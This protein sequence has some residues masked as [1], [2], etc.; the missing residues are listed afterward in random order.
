M[1]VF[2]LYLVTVLLIPLNAYPK[3][4]VEYRLVPAFPKLRFERPLDF[5]FAADGSTRLFVVEQAGRILVFENDS[6]VAVAKIFLDIKDR[7]S[8]RGNEEGLLGLA[9]DPKYRING[10]FYVYYSA[11]KPRRSVISRFSVSAKNKN[12]ANRA[13]EQIIMEVA[14]P[15]GNHNGGQI[16]FGFDGYLYIGLGDGG[17]GGDPKGNGQNLSTLLGS[18]LRIDV[19]K[20]SLDNPYTIPASNPYV[21]SLG[22]KGEIYA[23]GLRNPWR[24]SFDPVTKKLWAADV[25]Q[26][27]IEEI[28]I[29]TSGG[30]YGWNI[31][32]GS[33]CFN[34]RGKC[35]TAGLIK[36][37]YE[38]THAVGQSITGG[39]VYRGKALPGLV[40][41]YIYADFVSG[42]IWALDP[43]RT[44]KSRN[45]MLV[46]S[47]KNISSFGVDRAQEIY[48]LAFDGQVYRLAL[49]TKG[50]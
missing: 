12:V 43:K 42:K 10:Y 9:F 3:P 35:N 20:S 47:R 44:D 17:S 15:Y 8:S 21:N 48:I 4:S 33:S 24:F 25:G 37:V 38:Y 41:S 1:R 13:S 40:G 34:H 18:I 6:K 30:N 16:V 46:S 7:V 32:E 45:I 28:D 39:K 27:E 14:Q 36:P 50:R 49:K 22:K 26:S 31:Q 2:L 23:Y 29:I 5:Q 11:F 19:S